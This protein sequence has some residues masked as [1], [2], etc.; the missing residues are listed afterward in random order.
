MTGINGTDVKSAS[1][2][3]SLKHGFLKFVSST[4]SPKPYRNSL[5]AVYD[6][7][8]YS[9]EEMKRDINDD[10]SSWIFQD[11]S[12]SISFAPKIT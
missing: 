6:S 1:K 11:E 9:L 3:S 8:R 12:S 10:K 4:F 5:R 7:R 2:L